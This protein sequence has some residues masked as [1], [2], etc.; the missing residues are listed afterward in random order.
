ML[1]NPSCSSC[2]PHSPHSAQSGLLLDVRVGPLEQSLHLVSQVPRHLLGGNGTKR[3]EGK[4]LDILDLVLQVTA[5]RQADTNCTLVHTI[6][7]WI[8][9]ISLVCCFPA[10][11]SWSSPSITQLG[12][13]S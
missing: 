1:N 3:R 2:P 4:T 8:V 9:R 13:H 6:V 12:G 11:N 5:A 10:T 7:G